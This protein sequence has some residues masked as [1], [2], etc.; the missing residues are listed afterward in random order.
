MAS[1]DDSHLVNAGTTESPTDWRSVTKSNL[2]FYAAAVEADIVRDLGT[3]DLVGKPGL[4]ADSVLARRWIHGIIERLGIVPTEVAEFRLFKRFHDAI[5]IAGTPAAEIKPG[6]PDRLEPS[7]K[8][9]L[10]LF[11]RALQDVTEVS[12]TATDIAQLMQTTTDLVSGGSMSK[13]DALRG[14]I[15]CLIVRIRTY[16]EEA[17]AHAAESEQWRK[18]WKAAEERSSRGKCSQCSQRDSVG[19]I[20]GVGECCQECMDRLHE[21]DAANEM[22]KD[23]AADPPKPAFEILEGD[24]FAEVGCADSLNLYR[25]GIRYELDFPGDF[26]TLKASP[27][28]TKK[29]DERPIS[30]D[31]VDAIIRLRGFTPVRTAKPRA[32]VGNEFNNRE[33]IEFKAT[34]YLQNANGDF[35]AF[36]GT[37]GGRRWYKTPS[38]NHAWT[39]NDT[40]QVRISLKELKTSFPDDVWNLIALCEGETLKPLAEFEPAPVES[41]RDVLA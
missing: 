34:V 39:F 23:A 28:Q 3:G 2:L 25:D 37:A 10:E 38:R 13:D 36:D 19:G 22:F 27:D 7:E 8:I 31:N 1:Q 30:N 11:K 26:R 12:V 29:T 9:E 14:L 6:S 41:L 33:V 5:E 18:K 21:I 17:V 24:Q 4:Y 40:H 20:A 32:F 35:A 15:Q 16:R